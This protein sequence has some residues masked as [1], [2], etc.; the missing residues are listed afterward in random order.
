MPLSKNRVLAEG[1]TPHPWER[2]AIGFLKQALPDGEPYRLWALVELVDA[3]GRRHEID[4]L[5]LGFHA[6]Y[7]IEIKS[8]PG[9]VSGDAVDWTFE[10]PDGGRSTRENPLRLTS[11]KARVLASLLERKL[12][13]TR[14]WVEPLVFLSDPGIAVDLREQAAAGV[15]T[16]A[17][18]ARALT[19]GEVPGA[20]GRLGSKVINK[21][22]AQKVA[23]A[24]KEL[25]LAASK[26]ALRIGELVLSEVLEDGPGYQ[27]WEARHERMGEMRRR[28]RSYLVPQSP[29]QERRDQL[30]RAAEREARLLTVLGDHRS[31]LRVA[32]YVPE[33][34]T[35]GPCVVFDHLADSETL[36]A[37]IRRNHASLSFTHRIRIL[38]QLG[39]A[40][41][42]CH[43]KQV[44]HRGLN[45][46]AVLVRRGPDGEPEIR[47][48]NF[49]LA[50]QQDGSQGTAHLSAFSPD[51]MAVYRAP[52][53][54]EDPSKANAASDLF[55]LGA[56]AYYVLTGRHPGTNLPE[57]HQLLL[58]GH[59]SL[60]AASDELAPSGS[61]E[62]GHSS[63]DQV[64][65][66]AT[67][68]NPIERADNALEWVNLL[69][70][71][72]TAPRAAE[73]APIDPLEAR[74]G[75]TVGGGYL[76]V[77][78]LGTGSTSRVLQVSRDSSDYA[79]KIALSEEHAERLRA[80]A[81]VLERLESDRIVRLKE[82]LRI[83]GRT[84]LLLGYAGESLADV[85]AREGPV[86]LDYARRWG[87]DLLLAL[88]ALEEHG[89]AHRDIK[90]A[91][92]G[93]LPGAAKKARHLLLFDFSL[94]GLD[95]RAVEAG[96]PAYRDPFLA[97][98]GGWDEAADRYAAAV[99]LHELLTGVRPRYGTGETPAIATDDE[100]TVESERFDASVRDRLTA[101]FKKALAREVKSRHANA[102]ELRDD[103]LACF[104]AEAAETAEAPAGEA[105]ELEAQLDP[106]ASIE[107][108]PL[109]ARAKNAL[110]RSGVITFGELLQLPQNQLSGIRGVG[111]D[112]AKEILGFVTRYRAAWPDA[113]T[114]SAAPFCP[115]FK[116]ADGRVSA[117]LDLPPEAAATL[118]D[119]GLGRISL[120]AA[121]P[122]GR[123]ERVLA[124][125]P[126]A[127][128]KLSGILQA[129]SRCA[130]E[131]DPGTIEAWIEA[132]LAPARRKNDRRA[133]H[134]RLAFGLETLEGAPRGDIPSVAAALGVTPQAIYISLGRAREHWAQHAFLGTLR[135]AVGA[136]LASL[137]DVGR[138]DR[139]ASALP[140]FL[141]HAAGQAADEGAPI[142]AAAL[143]R[144]VGE[145]SDELVMERIR[146]EHWLAASSEHLAAARRLGNAADE[147]AERDPLPSSDEVQRALS[148][149]V[150]GT[151]LAAMPADRLVSI[152][153]NASAGAARSARLELYPRGLSPERAV[154]LCAAALG[155]SV[156]LTREEIAGIVRARYP[157]AAPLPPGPR[158]DEL[159]QELKLTWNEAR[160]RYERPAAEGAPTATVAPPGRKSTTHTSHRPKHDPLGQEAEAFEQKLRLALEKRY[161]RVLEVNAAHTLSATRQLA[162]RLKVAPRSIDEELLATAREVMRENEVEAEAV[163]AADRE[164]PN[165]AAWPVLRMMME[166]AA[167]RLAER[168]LSSEAPLILTE[169]GLLARYQ[170]S[171][172]VDR[173]VEASQG[174][175]APTI[176]FVVPALE[177]TGPAPIHAVTGNLSIQTTSPA[178]RVRVPASW[179]ENK[180]R[181]GFA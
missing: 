96:T 20:D 126:G 76:V 172:F 102:E 164:G 38:E 176:F 68:V 152:A 140:A 17:T 105:S 13:P 124:R 87:E 127:V 24:L 147:L 143:V 174:D 6:L 19:H 8:H 92:L 66:M 25:G 120:V 155:S 89:I 69:L 75:E 53:L 23:A 43:R 107:M 62:E 145:V 77:K 177:E 52:E 65:A 79:L 162:A 94:S 166:K 64:V 12:G 157:E 81:D 160:A 86:S 39:D 33:G 138:L 181:G 1:K 78:R 165:G 171:G 154:R 146:A 150:Q 173:L 144:V 2:E 10:F 82:R 151:P 168:L 11:H 139:V 101:F 27:D 84:C 49:Q 54:I 158:L 57:R 178:Q 60:A 91:N 26:A 14:P 74:P 99:T 125:H 73:Q 132:L 159:V 16:R 90:P 142:R 22:Q 97:A 117:L 5:V 134:V 85:L 28:V 61:P 59:L 4:A 70:E 88:G 41:D 121:A 21:P 15:V 112:T 180:H 175:A 32:D 148:A 113:S 104:R 170:L 7:L 149:F 115:G 179:I 18:L 48:F 30:R 116:G 169:P 47:L 130:A 161:F 71:A 36:D 29:T 51:P 100:V 167:S 128:D 163:F 156:A 103:W 93:V 44:V 98:R 80:E 109:S 141:P 131:G 114:G 83:G 153:A 110:D 106:D 136:A 108:L 56:V 119:A 129:E 37:F 31:I 3:S 118:E 46:G 122:R 111:R 58:D 40:L 9:R 133:Q 95:P 72:A 55:S 35:G 67:E 42:Y 34:P 123:V 45:P 63:L 135:E 50:S 137:G